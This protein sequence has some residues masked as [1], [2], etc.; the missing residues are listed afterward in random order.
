MVNRRC[1]DPVKLKYRRCDVCEHHYA[2]GE[3]TALACY[4]LIQKRLEDVDRLR[5]DTLRRFELAKDAVL[6]QGARP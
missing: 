6:R 1:E 5:T 3:H 4:E 2:V